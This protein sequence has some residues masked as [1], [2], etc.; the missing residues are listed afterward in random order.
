MP[1]DVSVENN[2]INL[3]FDE[4][5][6]DGEEIDLKLLLEQTKLSDLV[7][8]TIDLSKME[9]DT[10]AKVNDTDIKSISSLCFSNPMT[11]RDLVEGIDIVSIKDNI[12]LYKESGTYKVYFVDE[13]RA[14]ASFSEQ[15]LFEI[16]NLDFTNVKDIHIQPTFIALLYNNGSVKV[17]GSVAYY[18][19][20][21]YQ[22]TNITKLLSIN[23]L[24]VGIKNNGTIISCGM[25]NQYG[26]Q[27]YYNNRIEVF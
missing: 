21:S 25:V 1:N 18:K 27:Y 6:K 24:I 22:W 8:N 5:F 7:G 23:N 3:T 26:S 10:V 11:K 4:A 9:F 16:E 14:K 15:E 17:Y 19:I 13:N 12:I 2:V 20:T